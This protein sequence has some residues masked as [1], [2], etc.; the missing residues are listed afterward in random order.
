MHQAIDMGFGLDRAIA[1]HEKLAEGASPLMG[2]GNMLP[3]EILK[4]CLS[5]NEIPLKQNQYV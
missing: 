2:L 5:E 1:N 3:W 4:I